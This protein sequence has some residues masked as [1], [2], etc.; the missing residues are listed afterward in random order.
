MSDL[1]RIRKVRETCPCCGQHGVT[2]TTANIIST[3]RD[4]SDPGRRNGCAASGMDFDEA[5][6]AEGIQE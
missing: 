1:P 2:I 3:H 4:P 6:L 5:A